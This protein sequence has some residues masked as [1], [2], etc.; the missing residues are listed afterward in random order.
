ML[1]IAVV[2]DDPRDAALLKGYVEEY[3]KK[4]E[5]L[6]MIH[7]FHDGLD[8]IRSTENHDIVFLD[9][10]MGKLDGLETARFIRKINKETILIFVT[11][12]AQ[13]AIKGYEVEA[14]DFILKPVTM[15][16][17]VYVLDKAMRRLDGSGARA[18]FS[19]KTPEGTISLS[20]NDITFVEVFDHNL[21]YH[22][23]RGD[24]TV[25]GRLSDVNEKLD[26]ERFVMCNRSFIVNLRHVSNVTADY[27]LI[28]DTRISVSKSHR[29][30]L[31]KRFS[32]FLG[33]SL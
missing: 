14:L 11:N 10:Q 3:C 29:K 20:A 26:P 23:V 24:Y 19:L 5:Q 15:A 28:G 21:V 2:D 16:S 7:V 27:L 32:S 12:M 22:T 4:N 25:R 33:D 13:F 1:L 18:Q 8:L 30:E 9:I 6:A 17:I 31:M